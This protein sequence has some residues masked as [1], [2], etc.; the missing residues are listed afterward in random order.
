MDDKA[1]IDSNL[2][3]HDT[4]GVHMEIIGFC[5]PLNVSLDIMFLTNCRCFSNQIAESK[6]YSLEYANKVL[7]GNVGMAGIFPVNTN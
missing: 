1:V 2:T 7:E 3:I 5:H 6:I 4:L